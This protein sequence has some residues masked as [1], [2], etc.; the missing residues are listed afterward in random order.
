MTLGSKKSDTAPRFKAV[1]R[2]DRFSEVIARELR[3]LIRNRELLPNDRLPSEHALATEFNVSRPVVR[4]AMSQLKYDGM[5][6]SRPGSGAYVSQPSNINAF[7]ISEHCF[8]KRSEIIQIMEL[9]ATVGSAAALRAAQKCTPEKLVQMQDAFGRMRD[10]LA[11]GPSGVK[12]WLEAEFELY[13]AIAE[14]SENSFFCDLLMMINGRI[15]NQLQIAALNNVRV[16]EFTEAVL[17]EHAAVIDA[18]KKGQVKEAA[19]A[20]QRHF[21]NASSRTAARGDLRD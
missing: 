8:D 11:C 2:P 18:I 1:Q 21:S 15:K 6:E 3:S 9:Q 5:I 19:V 7:R 4:E 17:Q 16:A 14:A 12:D 10:A 20:A 13:L